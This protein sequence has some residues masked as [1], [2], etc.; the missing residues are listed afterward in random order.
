VIKFNLENGLHTI[1]IGQ[2]YNSN[3][4]Y[5]IMQ[6]FRS[7]AALCSK[8]AVDRTLIDLKIKFRQLL[9]KQIQHPC[10]SMPFYQNMY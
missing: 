3:P 9:S 8:D 7:L 10:S 5:A 2:D 6:L 1:T 4:I